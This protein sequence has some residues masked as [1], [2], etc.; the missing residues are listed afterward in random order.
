MEVKII[1]REDAP[2]TNITNCHGDPVNRDS[3][4]VIQRAQACTIGLSMDSDIK[5]RSSRG[6]W[7]GHVYIQGAKAQ[8]SPL[9]RSVTVF[10]SQRTAPVNVRFLSLSTKKKFIQ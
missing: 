1:Y 8:A 3:S 10:T 7:R 5:M 4:T 6:W 2:L 9:T